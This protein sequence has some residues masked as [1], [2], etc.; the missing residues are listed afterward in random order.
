MGNCLSA[1]GILLA[2]GTKGHRVVTPNTIIMIHRFSWGSWDKQAELLEHRHAED[3]EYSND[4]RFW[5]EASK[6][7]TNAL[8]EKNLLRP[9][10][11]WLS[12][13]EALSH[14]IIDKILKKPLE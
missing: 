7:K 2:A 9:T 5:T 14:G 6:W 11:T 1:G 8:L 12:A 10:D 3:I 4:T 13:E